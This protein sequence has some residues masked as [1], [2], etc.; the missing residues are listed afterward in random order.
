VRHHPRGVRIE[1]PELS[2][3]VVALRPLRPDDAVP[4]AAAFKADLATRA[5]GLLI[6]WAFGARGRRVDLVWFGLLEEEWRG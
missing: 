1:L 2:D 3:G 6:G 4:Y 5:V